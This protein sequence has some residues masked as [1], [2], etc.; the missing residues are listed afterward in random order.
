MYQSITEETAQGPHSLMQGVRDIVNDGFSLAN[1]LLF[2][3]SSMSRGY[4]RIELVLF[5]S[6][7]SFCPFQCL[8]LPNTLPHYLYY[9]QSSLVFL[10]WRRS[11]TSFLQ[12][13]SLLSCFCTLLRS[14]LSPDLKSLFFSFS[15]AWSSESLELRY[16]Y[17]WWIIL[18]TGWRWAEWWTGKHGWSSQRWER[19]TV[20]VTSAAV[21]RQC[22]R[23]YRLLYHQPMGV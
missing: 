14:S 16:Y 17:F 1:I 2:P 6:L 19:G 10:Y 5:T 15:R 13:T 3:T 7:F 18:H 21:K 8:Q 12:L 4:S 22:V 20:G 9:L 11:S 23:A